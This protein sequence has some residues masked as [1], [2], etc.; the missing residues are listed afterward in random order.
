MMSQASYACAAG[1]NL[2]MPAHLPFP[3][4]SLGRAASKALAQWGNGSIYKIRGQQQC[5]RRGKALKSRKFSDAS[6]RKIS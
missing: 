5:C 6:K 3:F 2:R 4:G 1:P